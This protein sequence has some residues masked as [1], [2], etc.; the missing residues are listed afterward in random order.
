MKFI[1]SLER[2]E[3]ENISFGHLQNQR[4][5]MNSNT[6]SSIDNSPLSPSDS[7]LI[8]KLT[9]SYVD[10]AYRAALR[11]ALSMLFKQ[12]NL[13][14]YKMNELLDTAC[15]VQSE[16]LLKAKTLQTQLDHANACVELQY[17]A[18][19]GMSDH[20]DSFASDSSTS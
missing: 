6:F 15:A 13:L 7:D 20:G 4:S 17:R 1:S 16:L 19:L 12:R 5:T 11:A 10:P 18:C 9:E 8:V 2:N 14:A 3:V